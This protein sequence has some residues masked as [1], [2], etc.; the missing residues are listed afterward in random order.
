MSGAIDVSMAFEPY[1]TKF[2]ENPNINVFSDLKEVTPPEGYLVS[3]ITMPKDFVQKNPEVVRR[4][5]KAFDRG[6]AKMNKNPEAACACLEKY[7]KLDAKLLMRIPMY[8]FYPGAQPHLIPVDQ[9]RS[10]AQKMKDQGVIDSVPA[11]KDFIWE[12]ARP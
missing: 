10:F 5:V 2:R 8:K 12:G 3:T 9:V 11:I 4:F 1:P 6:I 7:T